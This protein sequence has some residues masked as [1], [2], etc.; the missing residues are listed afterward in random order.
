M[1]EAAK[2]LPLIL[3]KLYRYNP[4][5]FAFHR[6]IYGTAAEGLLV[7]EILGWVTNSIK[8]IFGHHA[9]PLKSEHTPRSDPW[10]LRIPS[11]AARMVVSRDC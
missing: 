8:I 7:R 4:H 1:T 3:F 10:A 2:T 11:V 6:I 9:A 5:V